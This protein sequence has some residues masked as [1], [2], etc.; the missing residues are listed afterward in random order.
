MLRREGKVRPGDGRAGVQ[1]ERRKKEWGESKMEVGS[2]GRP[3]KRRENME[4]QSF[5]SDWV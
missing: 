4:A 5:C 1:K 3:S 2:H